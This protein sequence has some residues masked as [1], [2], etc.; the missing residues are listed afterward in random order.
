MSQN[1]YSI[2]EIREVITRLPEQFEKEPEV[3]TVTQHGKPIMAIH[4]WDLYES[5]IETLEVL[6]DPELMT[7]IRQGEQDIADGR[8]KLWEEVKKELGLE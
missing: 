3:I 5:I 8:G 2:S 4:P 7:A 1:V 6:G